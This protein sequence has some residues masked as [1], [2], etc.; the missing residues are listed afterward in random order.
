MEPGDLRFTACDDRWFVGEQ[1]DV[2]LVL[3]ASIARV[4]GDLVENAEL[5]QPPDEDVRGRVG[6]PRECLHVGDC[7]DRLVVERVEHAVAVPGG[8]TEVRSDGTS[9]L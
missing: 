9:M 7:D 4:A 1:S 3:E 2:R 5:H 6:R 8:A